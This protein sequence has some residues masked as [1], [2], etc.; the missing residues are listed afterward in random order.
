MLEHIQV[1][2]VHPLPDNTGSFIKPSAVVSQVLI[3]SGTIMTS[4]I[5][6]RTLQ[7]GRRSPEVI[8]ARTRQRPDRRFFHPWL[9]AAPVPKIIVE[10]LDYIPD[11]FQPVRELGLDVFPDIVLPFKLLPRQRTEKPPR[12]DLFDVG[13]DE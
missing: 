4:R 6:I 12:F 5:L 8:V 7:E 9:R 10:R 2:V 3:A 11:L 1:M 13:L